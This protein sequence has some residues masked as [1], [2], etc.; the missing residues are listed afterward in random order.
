MSGQE[1]RYGTTTFY[2]VDKTQEDR[3]GGVGLIDACIL[4]DGGR[5]K[6]AQW[7][8]LIEASDQADKLVTNL[9]EAQ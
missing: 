8:K 6:L 5:A 9:T 7:K 3:R 1:S 4:Q 2:L